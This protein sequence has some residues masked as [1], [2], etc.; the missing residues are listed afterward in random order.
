VGRYLVGLLDALGYRAHLRTYPNDHSYYR[1]AGL[2]KT[3]SQL[4]LFGWEADYQA[5]SAFFEPLFS[6]TAFQPDEPYNM[7][8][9]GFCDPQIDRHI[10]DASALQT[11]N[12][13]AADRAWQHIDREIMKHVPWIPLVNPVGIDLVSA[14][15]G[16]YQRTTAFGIPLDQLWV[17]N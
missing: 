16:N 6:C 3:H 10:A 4:G 11:T 2:A 13:A 15:V 5:G 7:N 14:K 8:P 1:Q 17:V 9:A 12:P